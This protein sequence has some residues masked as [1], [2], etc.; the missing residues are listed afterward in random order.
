MKHKQDLQDLQDE[1]KKIS[2]VNL[3][4]P[5]YFRKEPSCRV[6]TPGNNENRGAM[7]GQTGSLP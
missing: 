6:A 1:E 2:P 3:V 7:V 5:V 4:N